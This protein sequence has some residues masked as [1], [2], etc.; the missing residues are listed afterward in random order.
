[1]NSIV[2]VVI[3]ACIIMVVISLFIPR[4]YLIQFF[5]FDQQK[6]TPAERLKYIGFIG[7]AVIVIATLFT[8]VKSID[9]TQSSIELNQKSQLAI[10][11]KDAALLLASENTSSNL[12]GIYALHQI[13]KESG[14]SKEGD[15]GY[16]KTIQDILCAF[17]REN[18]NRGLFSST[19]RRNKPDFVFQTIMDVLNDNNNLI[20][21]SSN[22]NLSGSDLSL[23]YLS[24]ANLE[25]A[26]LC[27]TNLSKANLKRANLSRA[28]LHG[29]YLEGINLTEANLESADLLVANLQRAYLKGAN[30][31]SANLE[32]ANLQGADLQGAN[33]Q[34]ANL[35]GANLRGVNLELADLSREDLFSGA[36]L[37]GAD[38]REANLEEANVK[39][40]IIN[41]KTILTGTIYENYSKEELKK[42]FIFK[43]E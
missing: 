16:K 35:Q 18:N 23:L 6:R 40:A 4:K 33:L 37:Q 22:I 20:Y 43:E 29:A 11:F 12:S 7:G 17:I 19:F 10:R 9:L 38:L 36:N 41:N 34:G 30:L 25:G 32:N 5:G 24:G 28:Y 27:I 14:S 3:I 26:N 42:I 1:M 39:G 21:N 31:E 15:Q 2:F 13:A 8:T